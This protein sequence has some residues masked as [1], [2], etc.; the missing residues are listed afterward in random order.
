MTW[1]WIAVIVAVIG[2]AIAL[3]VGRGGAM[4]EV[5]P[6]RPAAQVPAGQL[7]SDDLAQVRFSQA[8]RGYAMD[9]VDDLIARV[10]IELTRRPPLEQT[11]VPRPAPE[12]AAE[13][14]AARTPLHPPTD[15]PDDPIEHDSAPLRASTDV[16][17]TV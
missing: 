13:A 10:R 12:P 14:P 4:P 17:P 7:T 3:V 1:L 9:E 15:D 2:A 8:L 11:V 6:D 5:A 16:G